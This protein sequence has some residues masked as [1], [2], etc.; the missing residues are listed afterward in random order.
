MSDLPHYRITRH[1]TIDCSRSGNLNAAYYDKDTQMLAI[2]FENT[3][4]Y[5]Y[6]LVDRETAEQFY[7]AESK[8]RFL[9]D[10]IKPV[11]DAQE[12]TFETVPTG[13]T[14][15]DI[16]DQAEGDLIGTMNW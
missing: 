12:C 7:Q 13:P 3:R 16:L 6:K 9:N 15:Q 1:Y 5:V 8:G 4:E 2:T 14:P 10:T 11:F